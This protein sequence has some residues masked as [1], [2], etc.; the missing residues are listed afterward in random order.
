[1]G[2]LLRVVI[3][4]AGEQLHKLVAFGGRRLPGDAS[5]LSRR[6]LYRED[7][8]GNRLEF[9]EPA[10]LRTTEAG[11]GE[12]AASAA[13]LPK[14][15]LMCDDLKVR[16]HAIDVLDPTPVIARLREQAREAQAKFELFEKMVTRLRG[17]L[18]EEAFLRRGDRVG[19]YLSG[20]AGCRFERMLRDWC[21]H[22]AQ[23]LSDRV[24]AKGQT[25]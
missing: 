21:V 22:A 23:A 18:D 13:A 12:P 15:L 25:L 11:V 14:P 5:L 24:Q 4:Q 19:S 10:P 1:M 17:D 7:P 6:L 9:L 8:Y 2:C 16:V 3:R 20:L